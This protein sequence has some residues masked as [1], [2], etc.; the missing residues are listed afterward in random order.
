MEVA[1]IHDYAIENIS[2]L[3]EGFKTECG[4]QTVHAWMTEQLGDK[5][6]GNIKFST[7]SHPM[8]IEDGKQH[9]KERIEGYL[10]QKGGFPE[11]D[12]TSYIASLEKQ[13]VEKMQTE[14]QKAT[15]K[16]IQK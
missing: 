6:A 1:S 7:G 16:T 15:N 10:S 13:A 5:I 4:A 8:N 11:E 12:I 3:I 9:Y 2:N 14:I